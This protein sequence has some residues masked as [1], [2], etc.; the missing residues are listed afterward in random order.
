MYENLGYHERPFI[1]IFKRGSDEIMSPNMIGRKQ[2]T[3]KM[4]KIND[5]TLQFSTRF[6]LNKSYRSSKKKQHSDV[7]FLC[8]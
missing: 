5:M 7:C 8:K 3:S 4:Q 2:L 1:L 6:F